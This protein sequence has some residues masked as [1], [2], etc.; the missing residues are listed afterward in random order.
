MS[1]PLVMTLLSTKG[2]ADVTSF[3]FHAA[4][5]VCAGEMVVMADEYSRFAI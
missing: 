3:D 4:E 5:T 1:P 2:I